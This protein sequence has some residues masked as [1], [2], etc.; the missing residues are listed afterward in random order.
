W[1]QTAGLYAGLDLRGT[2]V[3]VSDDE[4][5]AAVGIPHDLAVVTLALFRHSHADGKRHLKL[6]HAGPDLVVGNGF[7]DFAGPE[8]VKLAR[9]LVKEHLVG[10]EGIVAVKLRADRYGIGFPVFF[11]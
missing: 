9:V 5:F 11:K 2:A 8:V 4:R 7:P 3:A 10:V 1:S 6:V